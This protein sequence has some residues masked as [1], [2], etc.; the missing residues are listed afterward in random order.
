MSQ[1]I[2]L[3]TINGIKTE[4]PPIWMMRQAGRVLPSYMKLRETYGFKEM[5]ETPDLAA[6]VTMLPIR[7]LG[8]DAAILFSDILVI[9]EA[10]GMEL[11]FEGKGPSFATALKDVTDPLGFLV[12]KPERLE[13]IY[14]AIDRIIEIKPKEIPLIG[15][16]G[17]PLTT[18]CYMYQGFS[19][20]QNFPDFVPAI[21]RDKAL[22]KKVVDRITEMSIHYALKQVEHG[23]EAFQLFETHAG[24]I[25]VELYKEVFLPS[26]KAILKAVREKG[27][28]TIYLPKGLGTGINMVN[29]DLCDCVSVDWQTPLHEVRNIV[30][31]EM[32]LQGNFDPRILES[33]KEAVEQEFKYYLDYGRKDHKWIFNL[34]HGLLPSI[35][36]ENVEHLVKLVKESDWGR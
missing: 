19:R 14:K 27:V 1:S 29:Y 36:V 17:G 3:D 21:Y 8:V 25:P 28:K 12:D 24:L 16:C 2:F 26:V 10:L 18:L 11:S 35:P 32:I 9:P 6:D 4:R 30:G 34:G 7:D 33:T 22:M 13:H 15:F 20:N 5:M 31:D 23:V